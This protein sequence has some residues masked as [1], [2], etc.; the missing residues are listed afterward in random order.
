MNEENEYLK[1]IKIFEKYLMNMNKKELVKW[2]VG[3]IVGNDE[4]ITK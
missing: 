1:R 3:Y 4:R 2:I